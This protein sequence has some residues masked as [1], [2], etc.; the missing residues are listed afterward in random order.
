MRGR[1]ARRLARRHREEEGRAGRRVLAARRA[2][3]NRIGGRLVAEV[4]K[5]LF[6]DAGAARRRCDPGASPARRGLVT[7]ADMADMV[8]AT[9]RRA[10]AG[11]KSRVGLKGR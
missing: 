1:G 4:V 6:R 9:T 7:S 2:A 8:G 5:R 3:R 11:L 10:A